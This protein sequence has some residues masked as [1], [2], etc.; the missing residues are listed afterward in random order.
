M[1][2]SR[3]NIYFFLLLLLFVS[4]GKA[5]VPKPRG[6]YRIDLPQPS[7]HRFE[8]KGFPYSFCISDYSYITPHNSDE[9][10]WIDV[11]YPKWGAAIHCSYKKVSN[12]LDQLT[13]DAFDFV[14]KHAGKA[15]AIPEVEYTNTEE[16]V[17]GIFFELH[18]NTAS[19]Y[20]FYLTDSIDNFF[21]GATYF[22]AIPN[23]DSLQPVVD[24]LQT[25]IKQMIETFKWQ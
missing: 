11:V 17:Y 18:G 20:Q 19:P 6:Y 9:Q 10:Y 12:N 1:I 3:N 7:Y 24:Y 22:N 15:T 8:Q 13:N 4:C 21:R 14:Y 2:R 25:D 5:P 23:Q 16:H